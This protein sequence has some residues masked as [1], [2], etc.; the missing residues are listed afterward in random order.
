MTSLD[1]AAK[2]VLFCSL[3]LPN[4][5]SF[6]RS[7]NAEMSDKYTLAIAVGV[8]STLFFLAKH[9]GQ[10]RD[11]TDTSAPRLRLESKF[12]IPEVK[13]NR[14]KLE[15]ISRKY[16]LQVRELITHSS[17]EMGTTD[18]D[19]TERMFVLPDPASYVFLIGDVERTG[20]IC[21]GANTYEFVE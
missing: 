4:R 8:N 20:R 5:I 12:R 14:R 17:T 7:T 16:E 11:G 1:N 10:C 18:L 13:L 6:S 3:S 9:T 15:K 21:D 19:S 2:R